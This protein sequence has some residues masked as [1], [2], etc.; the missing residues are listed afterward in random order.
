MT[1]LQPMTKVLIIGSG[2]AGSALAQILRKDNV[3]FEIFERDSGTR[4]QGWTIAL[5]ESECLEDLSRLL[6]EDIPNLA[7]ASP[8]FHLNKIDSFT[9]MDGMTHQVL[10]VTNTKNMGGSVPSVFANRLNLRDVLTKHVKIQYSKHFVRYEEDRDGVTIYFKD[11][12]SARGDIL[13]GADGANSLVRNQLLPGFKA[14][15]S[16]YLTALCKVILTKDLYEPLLEHSSNG[17]LIAAPN[18]KAYCLLMEYLEDGRAT[19]NWT[20]SWRSKDPTEHAEMVAAGP[21]AQLGTVKELLKDFPSIM[22]NAIAQSKA[23]DLQWPPVRLMETVLPLQGL[24]RGRITLLGDGAHS[25]V[26][27][28]GMGANTAL[29]DAC[30]LGEGLTK[31]V[32][33]KE[34]LQWVLQTYE[35]K[36]IPRGRQKVLESRATADS[37]DAHEISGGR[38]KANGTSIPIPVR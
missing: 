12:T 35:E 30:N 21:A 10:G 2:L 26:P 9:V 28:R 5:D 7:T 18:V 15:P 36:M 6:P 34:D 29:L 32:Q 4:P 16:P 33:A 19:F 22:V 38:I 8:N 24:P 20:V 23:S 11:G 17:P 25:M 27:F 31:G 1:V 37:D 14:D 3:Q 13:V